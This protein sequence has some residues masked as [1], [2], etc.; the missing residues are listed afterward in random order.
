MSIKHLMAWQ[1][2]NWARIFRRSLHGAIPFIASAILLLFSWFNRKTWLLWDITVLGASLL[3]LPLIP[4]FCSRKK[5]PLSLR[6]FSP[7]FIGIG[8][9]IQ[10]IAGALEPLY[11]KVWHAPIDLWPRWVIALLLCSTMFYHN[12]LKERAVARGS[13]PLSCWAFPSNDPSVRRMILF[14]SHYASANGLFC[15]ALVILLSTIRTLFPLWWAQCLEI[16]FPLYL[17]CMVGSTGFFW[18]LSG[19]TQFSKFLGRYSVAY[20]GLLLA[21]II[22]TLSFLKPL[23]LPDSLFEWAH[24]VNDWLMTPLLIASNGLEMT[25]SAALSS[26]SLFILAC[27]KIYQV[28]SS[29]KVRRLVLSLELLVWVIPFICC[30][31][32]PHLYVQSLSLKSIQI[33]VLKALSLSLHR[34]RIS[35]PLGILLLSLPLFSGLMRRFKPSVPEYA[36]VA[37]GMLIPLPSWGSQPLLGLLLLLGVFVANA[38]SS[39]HLIYACDAPW[40]PCQRS[41][42]KARRWIVPVSFSCWALMLSNLLIPQQICFIVIENFGL[43]FM[44]SLILVALLELSLAVEHQIKSWYSN[45]HHY[46][47]LLTA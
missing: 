38:L 24:P 31:A 41:F 25:R 27:L 4:A 6:W 28:Q 17:C 26:G 14:L 15:F 9:Y 47:A 19:N 36:F 20:W 2:R 8:A 1:T 11:G 32:W 13:A 39:R 3:F 42:I 23:A 21:F 16:S 34:Y 40:E 22:L 44:F 45:R 18:L 33:F 12:S 10:L 46:P 29:Q 43:L 5:I 7:F 30:F 37:L 35:Q